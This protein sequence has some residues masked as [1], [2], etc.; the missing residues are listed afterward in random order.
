MLSFRE[1]K[2]ATT[3]EVRANKKRYKGLT[4]LSREMKYAERKLKKIRAERREAREIKD[5]TKR[6]SELQRLFE[7][8]R[9]VIMEF[10][11]IYNNVKGK[12]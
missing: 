9:K 12:K 8:E 2:N 7:E 11:R 4:R 3:K 6:T 10:N 1:Y 5:Y